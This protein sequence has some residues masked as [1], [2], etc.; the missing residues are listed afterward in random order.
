[1]YTQA[2]IVSFLAGQH[3][4]RPHAVQEIETAAALPPSFLDKMTTV[5]S[6]SPIG[7]IHELR[8]KLF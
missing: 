2:A 6:H 4:Q 8:A 7:L 1:M 3:G 5:P